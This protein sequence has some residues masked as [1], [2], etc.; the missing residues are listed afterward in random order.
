MEAVV[1]RYRALSYVVGVMLILL[2]FVAI[3]IRY[4]GGEPIVSAFVSPVHGVLYMFY[5]AVAF[6]LWRKAGWPL[7]KMVLMVSSGLLPFLAFFVERKISREAL[8]VSVLAR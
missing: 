4:I 2:V 3:P 1:S 6:D 7:S 8:T 5:L